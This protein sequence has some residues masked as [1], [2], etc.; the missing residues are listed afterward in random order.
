MTRSGSIF[1]LF[2]RLVYKYLI[3]HTFAYFVILYCHRY[4]Y[5]TACFVFVQVW[6]TNLKQRDRGNQ[7][8]KVQVLLV[9]LDH[10]TYLH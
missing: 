8:E 10:T 2:E 6:E 9:F 3:N 5:S 7:R 1:M 4:L